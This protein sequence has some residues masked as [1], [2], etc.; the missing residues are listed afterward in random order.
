MISGIG[1]SSAHLASQIFSRLDTRQQGYI[2]K[3][4]LATAFSQI[5]DSGSSGSSSFGID[6]VFTALDGDSDGK[7]TE[8]ELS[9]ALGKLKEE[10]DSQF[11]QMRMQGMPGQGPQGM[12]GGMPPP[13]PSGSREEESDSGFSVDELSSQ[14]EEIGSSDSQ[15]SS[16]IA[17]IVDNFD[18]ADSDGDG[19]VNRSEAMS[20]GESLRQTSTGGSA[21]SSSSSQD[22]GSSDSSSNT[23]VMKKI[24]QLIH[25]YGQG[26]QEQSSSE[27]LSRLS[28]SA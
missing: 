10:L 1:L 28:V 4:D 26:G 5:G 25:A 23:A 17:S 20:Y 3:A 16:L 15:R 22:S 14:L 9:S 6:E 12:G 19:K 2:E 7:V 18:A 13:P 8:N 11:S 21:D 24:M 27:L